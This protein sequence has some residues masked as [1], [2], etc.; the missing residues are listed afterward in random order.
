MLSQKTKY[1]LKAL[2]FLAQQEEGYIARTSEIAEGANIPKKFLE[3]ILLELKRGH[4]VTPK[5][6]LYYFS[7]FSIKIP[8]QKCQLKKDQL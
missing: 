1:A 4:F 8:I 6:L 7:T 3:Q 2:L 5:Y